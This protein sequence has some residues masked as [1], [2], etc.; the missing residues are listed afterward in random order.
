MKKRII[1]SVLLVCSILF[2]SCADSGT[3]T[4]GIVDDV[5]TEASQASANTDESVSSSEGSISIPPVSSYHS[6]VLNSVFSNTVSSQKTP[7]SSQ[8]DISSFKGSSEISSSKSSDKWNSCE[9]ILP[10]NSTKP[11]DEL[12]KTTYPQE[13]LFSE[14]F[15][16]N[17]L[18]N[19]IR[20]TY[21][22]EIDRCFPA[23]CIRSFDN[24]SSVYVV[25][26]SKEGSY[27]YIFFHKIEVGS[28]YFYPIQWLFVVKKPLTKERFNSVKNGDTLETIETVDPG[29]K[30]YRGYCTGKYKSAYLSG[31]YYSDGK[32]QSYHMVKDGFV[33]INY[34]LKNPEKGYVESNVIVKSVE[35]TPNGDKMTIR[36]NK[37]ELLP[38][39]YPL[40]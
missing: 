20:D 7:V 4:A 29:L 40:K 5:S 15:V 1:V 34:S 35:Y 33:T 8:K 38:G 16:N 37:I 13:E 32:L 17:V 11:V 25:Y 12:I 3:K 24:D 2:T 23:E 10:R 22:L 30:A 26:K 31:L 18:V 27:V 19:F 36:G 21:L 9:E 28:A 39:D 14:T 6:S